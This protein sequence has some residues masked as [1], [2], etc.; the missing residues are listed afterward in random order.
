M[1]KKMLIDATHSEETRVVVMDGTR[2]E[3][4]EVESTHK[5]QLKGNVYLAKVIRVEP[6]LQAAFVDYGGGRHGFL[7]FSEIHPDYYQI[8]V[9]DREAIF[10]EEE[11][12][13]RKRM[14]EKAEGKY[15]SSNANTV[16]ET[17]EET[18]DVASFKT[19]S[20]LLT[21]TSGDYS[22]SEDLQLCEY[23]AVEEVVKADKTD[24]INSPEKVE[25]AVA[26]N[27]DKLPEVSIIDD[28]NGEDK[29][30][31]TM[32]SESDEISTAEQDNTPS[33]PANAKRLIYSGE[34]LDAKNK[35]AYNNVLT[36]SSDYS[37]FPAK[38]VKPETKDNE[39]SSSA[40][41]VRNDDVDELDDMARKH[42]A[43]QRRYK[44]QEVINNRQ[45]LLVQVVK[46]ER[47]NKGAALT[48]YL[49]LAGRY[50]VLMP[51][52]TRGGGV[53]RKITHIND[54]RRLKT[55]VSELPT[56][57]GMS[58][59]VRTAGAERKRSEIKRDFEYLI[60]LWDNIRKTT[61][62]SSAPSIIHEEAN[63]IKRAIRDIYTSDISE[64]I[65]EGD[66]E[67]HIAK[68]FMK[69]LTPSHAKK[70]QPYDTS[71]V[72][73]FQ[74]HRVEAQLEA[75][76]RP[77]AQLPSGGY[78]VINQTEALVAIDVNSG[79][80]TK[81]RNVEKTALHTNLESADEVARQL[82]LRD[83]AGLVVIDFIDMEQ[84]K[85]NA[86]VE[87][88]M[89]EALKKDR[90]R[91][92]MAKISP[93]GLM[94]LSRQR[95]HPSVIETSYSV[96]PHCKGTGMI[97]SVESSAIYFLH[98][99][100]EECCKGRYSELTMNVPTSVAIYMLNN[101]RESILEME[102]RYDMKII[103][104]GDNS[105]TFATEHTIDRV[106]APTTR[107]KK[108]VQEKETRTEDS[109]AK[110]EKTIKKEKETR[111]P[112]GSR[113]RRRRKPSDDKIKRSPADTGAITKNEKDS[114]GSDSSNE[115]DNTTST[116]SEKTEEYSNSNSDDKGRRRTPWGRKRRYKKNDNGDTASN[117]KSKTVTS[118]SGDNGIPVVAKK[119]A[120]TT[121]AVKEEAKKT[122]T[123]SPKPAAKKTTSTPKEKPVD[124]NKPK[125][126]G[127]WNKLIS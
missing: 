23:A 52:N 118:E 106:K 73:L 83:M 103:L 21:K 3:E 101:K 54:R 113:K 102:A 104:N 123:S 45:I 15:N 16:E 61:V 68:N 20:D 24:E 57:K 38:F 60:R 84:Y 87:R 28:T 82:R 53:S 110:E 26:Q 90:A 59:I 85:N 127:W 96:C 31:D 97:R 1:V 109:D 65:V 67:Y 86:A 41:T 114:I 48:T 42:R 95:L 49:S 51:N 92:Q 36:N 12:N 99:L 56:E 124:K 7:S 9:A 39:D 58:V 125:K 119:V 44:I 66:D 120:S 98:V 74:K 5:K 13:H 33:L 93:F 37:P 11:R 79:R 6:S 89:R 22:S 112:K 70:V 29:D 81:E 46:E 94:E 122:E 47:G 40:E 30:E 8:P 105:F 62:S 121:P 50:C 10:A 88:R 117:N 34:Y 19:S 126:S 75:M 116:A 32:V 4:Y 63:L 100:E 71:G 35:D 27:E 18:K 108:P 76:H 80:S 25:T 2:L 107:C 69:M 111:D 43:I 55:I 17:D 91:I 78:L 72:S 14:A 115:A 64:I 77:I